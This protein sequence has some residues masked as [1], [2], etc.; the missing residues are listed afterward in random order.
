MNLKAPLRIA[1]FPEYFYPHVGGAETWTVNMA[2]CLTSLGHHVEVFTYRMPTA[3]VD[4]TLYGV[5]VHRIGK[6]F[7]IAGS[8][9]YFKRVPIHAISSFLALMKSKRFDVVIAQYTPLLSLKLVSLIRATP[10]VA[11]FHDVYGLESSIEQKGLLRGLIRYVFGDLLLTGFRYDGVVAVS[12]AT[13]RKLRCFGCETTQI[14]VVRNGVN[15]DL[16]DSIVAVRIPKQICFVGRLL[17]HKHV[18]DLLISFARVLKSERNAKLIVIGDGDE[19]NKLV[20]LAQELGIGGSVNF[21]GFVGDKEKIRLMKSSELLVLP[22]TEEGWANVV[23]EAVYCGLTA[24]AYD[25]PALREQSRFF[26]S[27]VLVPARNI[28]AL[29]G[30]IEQSLNRTD[31]GNVVADSAIIRSNFTWMR[32]AEELQQFLYLIKQRDF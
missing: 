20:S 4:Q 3:T 23:T 12:D 29:A 10:I 16:I 15:V 7:V 5:S 14:K 19:K 27:I 18:D 24:V 31:H 30:A 17:K 21:T 28:D 11:V 8:R 32:R 22:S 13:E 25:I 2:R 6:P 9:P 1:F 26:H